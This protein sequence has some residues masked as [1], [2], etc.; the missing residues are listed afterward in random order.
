M[1]EGGRREEGRREGGREEGEIKGGG[2][3]R[4]GGKEGG[5]ER[6][7]RDK[8]GERGREG[9]EEITNSDIQSRGEVPY[10]YIKSS[11]FTEYFPEEAQPWFIISTAITIQHHFR[12]G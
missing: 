11:W 4:E 3:G 12:V 2:G 6:G 10:L 7:R 5:R 1:R 8:G 9:G